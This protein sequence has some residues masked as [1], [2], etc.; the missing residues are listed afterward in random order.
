MSLFTREQRAIIS[1]VREIAVEEG[2]A[3]GVLVN[4][5]AGSGKTRTLIESVKTLLC[6]GVIPDDIIVI[7]FTRNAA[8]QLQHRLGLQDSG[9]MVDT[10]HAIAMRLVDT[11]GEC[12]HAF[13]WAGID[14]DGDGDGGDGDG[15]GANDSD[16]KEIYGLCEYPGKLNAWLKES[17]EGRHFARGIRFLVIDEYQDCDEVQCEI[18]K[19]F[20]N[21]S[22]LAFGDEDQNIFT[23]RGSGSGMG[24]SAFTGLK[25]MSLTENFRSSPEIVAIANTLLP[26]ISPGTTPTTMFTSSRRTGLLPTLVYAKSRCEEI[27]YAIDTIETWVALGVPLN[28]CAI[29]SNENRILNMIEEETILC[30][31]PCTRLRS[32]KDN[33]SIAILTIH[34]AKGLEWDNVIITGCSDSSFPRFK[35]SEDQVNENRRVFYV[36]LTRARKK[37]VMTF[38]GSSCTPSRFLVPALTNQSKSRH[39]VVNLDGIDD[40]TIQ[41]GIK[42]I[43]MTSARPSP[44]SRSNSGYTPS[45]TCM[46]VRETMRRLKPADFTQMRERGILPLHVF[47]DGGFNGHNGALGMTRSRFVEEQGLDNSFCEIARAA[48]LLSL[49]LTPVTSAVIA[50]ETHYSEDVPL[51]HAVPLREALTMLSRNPCARTVRENPRALILYA[52][53][54]SASERTNRG[55]KRLFHV[56]PDEMSLD[57][58]FASAAES[59]AHSLTR[60][61]KVE[62]RDSVYL[63]SQNGDTAC[64]S[65][66]VFVKGYLLTFCSQQPDAETIA[67]SIISLAMVTRWYDSQEDSYESTPRP[68]GGGA[69]PNTDKLLFFDVVSGTAWVVKMQMQMVE[70]ENDAVSSMSTSSTYS[71]SSFDVSS[72]IGFTKEVLDRGA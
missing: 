17:E 44:R 23:W 16:G 67:A 68:N 63:A 38:S 41:A 61:G 12:G 20:K 60:I 40:A 13:A 43:E 31:I 51:S 46:S 30:G 54:L 48:I 35:D 24:R 15:D 47:L 52:A 39:M 3:P 5:V 36:A 7:T 62:I 64:L 27:R 28:Q 26:V 49:N 53:L 33:L 45:R 42:T 56:T 32:D 10:F 11:Q 19:E 34:T 4:A 37:L 50:A 25:Q 55:R 70:E 72:I 66:P 65:A 58:S 1:A 8:E 22:V 18:L 59:A 29:L 9:M 21:A 6:N 14:G 57:S 2:S 71:S 69:R